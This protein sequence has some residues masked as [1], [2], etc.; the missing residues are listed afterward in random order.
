VTTASFF[1][2]L[3]FPRRYDM[4]PSGE[5]FLMVQSLEE[6]FTLGV[7]VRVVVNWFAELQQ[8]VA[9]P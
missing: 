1:Q 9:D 7:P 4:D 5:R 2:A 3:G 8:R 6:T